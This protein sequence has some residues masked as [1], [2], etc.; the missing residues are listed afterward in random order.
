M[1]EIFHLKLKKYSQ[2]LIVVCFTS[3]PFEPVFPIYIKGLYIIGLSVFILPYL[4]AKSNHHRYL[5]LL[6]ICGNHPCC[7]F[8][9]GGIFIFCYPS[10][11]S[12]YLVNLEH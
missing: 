8:L 5:P 12:A 10:T 9:L 4:F 2:Y 1:W 7:E 11:L 6:D 3:K